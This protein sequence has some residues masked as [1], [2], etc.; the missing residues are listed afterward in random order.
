MQF[1][2]VF[3]IKIFT[4]KILWNSIGILQTLYPKIASLKNCFAITFIEKQSCRS[5]I[6][7]F[8]ENRF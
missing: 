5:I 1:Q 8:I 4:I 2:N 3:L 6:D 7:N